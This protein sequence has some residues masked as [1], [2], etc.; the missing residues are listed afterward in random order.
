MQSFDPNKWK[1]Y[2]WKNWM[3]FHWLINPGLAFNEL[4]LGQ[5][6][7][8]VMVEDKTSNKPR[9]ERSFVPCPHCGEMHDSQIWSTDRLAFK[10][11]FGLYCTSCGQIIPCLRNVTSSVLLVLLYP[12]WRPFYKSQ[13]EKWLSAQPARYASLPTTK[14]ENTYGGKRWIING[15]VFGAI[16]WCL[17][18]GMIVFE[19]NAISTLQLAKSVAVYSIGGLFFGYTMKL[20]T[21]A[22]G[23]S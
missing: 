18:V 7:P 4:L 23:A 19:G 20:F 17:F 6:V 9:V 11:W 2:T 15:L 13:K 3:V 16:M 1:V 8:K 10:N 21:S 5:R 12:I 14:V 22:R